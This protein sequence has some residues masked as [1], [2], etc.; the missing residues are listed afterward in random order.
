MKCKIDKW[1]VFNNKMLGEWVDYLMVIKFQ[2]E[3]PKKKDSDFDF[4]LNKSTIIK[5]VPDIC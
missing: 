5:H 1:I 4:F 3:N 2:Y